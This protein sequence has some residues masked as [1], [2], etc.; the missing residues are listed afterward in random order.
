M[1]RVAELDKRNTMTSK[2]DDARIKRKNVCCCQR[3]KQ[4]VH[5]VYV[6]VLTV[7]FFSTCT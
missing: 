7:F 6:V 4:Y 5:V 1:Q 3:T 2:F